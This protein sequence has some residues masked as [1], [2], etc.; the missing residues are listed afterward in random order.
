[1]KYVVLVLLYT[2]IS[3]IFGQLY[4]DVI[5]GGFSAHFVSIA[6]FGFCIGIVVSL[7]IN[8]KVIGVLVSAIAGFFMIDFGIGLNELIKGRGFSSMFDVLS[9]SFGGAQPALINRIIA[10]IPCVTAFLVF[11][12]IAKDKVAIAGIA[13]TAAIGLISIVAS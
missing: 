6:S 11:R 2:L 7:Y 13:V 3:F 1:M 10:A 5:E 8:L 12:E 4:L 9:R